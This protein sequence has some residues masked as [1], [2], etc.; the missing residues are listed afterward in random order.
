MTDDD[1]LKTYIASIKQAFIAV[2]GNMYCFK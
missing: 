2:N 1:D